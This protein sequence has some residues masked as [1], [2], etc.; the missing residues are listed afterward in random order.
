LSAKNGK[1]SD[2]GSNGNFNNGDRKFESPEKEWRGLPVNPESG[3]IAFQ[4]VFNCSAD[5]LERPL[6]FS[7]EPVA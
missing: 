3:S 5:S 6:E 2:C 1:L 7:E 4:N